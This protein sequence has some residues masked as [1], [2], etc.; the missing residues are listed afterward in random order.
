MSIWISQVIDAIE[1]PLVSNFH[2]DKLFGISRFDDIKV[3]KL[4]ASPEKLKLRVQSITNVVF[5]RFPT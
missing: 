3:S 5:R 2:I 4:I 1:I